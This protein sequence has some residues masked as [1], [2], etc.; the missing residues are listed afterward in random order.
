[1]V[2]SPAAFLLI[3]VFIWVL[4]TRFPEQNEEEINAAA[5]FE[6]RSHSGVR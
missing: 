1:M 2:L 5:L 3:G 6:H 4:R